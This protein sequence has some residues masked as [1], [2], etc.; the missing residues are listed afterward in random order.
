LSATTQS[1]L[2]TLALLAANF[3]P[4]CGVLFWGWPLS[5]LLAL[6]WAETAVIGVFNVFRMLMIQPLAAVPLSLFFAVHFGGFMFVHGMFLTMM[7]LGPTG[8]MG[9]GSLLAMVEGVRWELLALVASH[10]VSFV[11]YWIIGNEAEGKSLPKQMLAPYR[12]I[13]VM[14][15]SILFGGFAVSILGQPGWMLGLFVV[16]KIAADLRAHRR[17]HRSSSS[18]DRGATL[19]DFPEPRN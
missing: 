14:H 15:L 19:N 3:L 13:I 18:V 10:G 16:L 1:R 12:R 11:V 6:Y 8:D 17:E 2:S 7:F 4:L 5:H 9:A